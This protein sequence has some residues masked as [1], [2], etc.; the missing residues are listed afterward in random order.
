MGEWISVEDANPDRDGIYPVM[1][2]T[3]SVEKRKHE[4]RALF[5]NGRWCKFDWQKVTHW[6]PEPPKQGEDR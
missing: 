3:G 5:N 6:K 1:C 4:T 2:L